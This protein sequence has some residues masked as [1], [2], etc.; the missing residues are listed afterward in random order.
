V[1]NDSE[2]T[3]V[4]IWDQNQISERSSSKLKFRRRSWKI[5]RRRKSQISW[6]TERR[7]RQPR[8]SEVEFKGKAGGSIADAKSEVDRKAEPETTATGESRR[9]SS[10]VRLEGR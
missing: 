9:L 4:V 10:K 7:M 8:E 3:S 2:V 5:D 6:K 1:P